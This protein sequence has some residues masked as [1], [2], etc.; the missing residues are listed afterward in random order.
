MMFV[1]DLARLYKTERGPRAPPGDQCG[2]GLVRL[3]SPI[4]C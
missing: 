3:G 1:V 2:I 4:A